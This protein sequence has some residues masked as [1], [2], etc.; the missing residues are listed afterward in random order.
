M[1]TTAHVH[2][3]ATTAIHTLAAIRTAA[4][5][6]DNGEINVFDALDSI[7]VA[8]EAYRA[9]AHAETHREAA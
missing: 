8:V 2:S 7:V 3:L 9:A 6:F 4:E 5:T 1:M